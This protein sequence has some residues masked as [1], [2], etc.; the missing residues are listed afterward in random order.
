MANIFVEMGLE[1]EVPD[2]AVR[3]LRSPENLRPDPSQLPQGEEL[4]DLFEDIHRMSHG[5]A[6]LHGG[7]VYY[8][9]ELGVYSREIFFIRD[10]KVFI[11]ITPPTEKS[12]L[13]HQPF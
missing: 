4:A 9:K 7:N 3:G 8:Y 2:Y 11:P 5:L 10:G 1:R 13:T 12:N 6:P